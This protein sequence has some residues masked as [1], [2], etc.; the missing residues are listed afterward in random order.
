MEEV[1]T[2]EKEI[3]RRIT[4][5]TEE[6]ERKQKVCN[7]RA[8]QIDE[9]QRKLDGDIL[10]EIIDQ[11]TAVREDEEIQQLLIVQSNEQVQINWLKDEKDKEI[12]NLRKVQDALI[13][14]F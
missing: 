9:K 5:L 14:R 10:N 3:K 1:V 8:Q 2:T 12:Q 11:K 7:G 6:I 4:S 13:Q